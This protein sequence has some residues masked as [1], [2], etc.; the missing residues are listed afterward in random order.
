[1]SLKEIVENN[2]SYYSHIGKLSSDKISYLLEKNSQIDS[3]KTELNFINNLVSKG[4][5]KEK[6]D[7]Q[8]DSDNDNI[9]SKDY[10][11]RHNLDIQE[12]KLKYFSNYRNPCTYIENK[13]KKE[14]KNEKN[15]NVKNENE[16]KTEDKNKIKAKK[17]LQKIMDSGFN[18]SYYHHLL[19]HTSDANFYS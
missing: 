14:N 19:H 16:K 5:N 8:Y 12:Q 7:I 11:N 13:V 9:F 18:F 2:K 17:E 6:T 1:M 3:G 15:K 4:R 10:D